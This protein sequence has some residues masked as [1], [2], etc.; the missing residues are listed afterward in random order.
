M[1]ESILGAVWAAVEEN[2]IKSR[3]TSQEVRAFVGARPAA[4]EVERRGRIRRHLW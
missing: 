3:E 2:E 1:T 4:V